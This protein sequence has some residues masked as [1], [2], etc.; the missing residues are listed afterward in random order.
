MP[1]LRLPRSASQLLRQ[2]QGLLA[3]RTPR[4]RL[5]LALAA[6]I[7]AAA[8]AYLGYEALMRDR[9]RLARQLPKLQV[10]RDRMQRDAASL[11]QLRHQPAATH[12]PIAQRLAAAQA[13]AAGRGLKLTLTME[14]DLIAAS[15]EGSQEAIFG[16]LADIATNTGLYPAKLTVARVPQGEPSLMSLR[17]ELQGGTP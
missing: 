3:Q 12:A 9:Q 5:A 11:E 10:L 15:G 7:I 13:A 14:G 16:W 1:T 4:E 17:T 8:L 6:S 2:W